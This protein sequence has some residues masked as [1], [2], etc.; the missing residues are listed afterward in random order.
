M[1]ERLHTKPGDANTRACV[2]VCAQA[3]ATRKRNARAVF[4][5]WILPRGSD[6]KEENEKVDNERVDCIEEKK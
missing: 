1:C 4:V 5:E 2:C 6:S 3:A